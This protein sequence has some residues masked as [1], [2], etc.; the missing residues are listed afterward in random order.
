MPAA[1]LL[2]ACAA[3]EIS[4]SG[5]RVDDADIE[6]LRDLIPPI[7][8][9]V[10]MDP[11]GIDILSDDDLVLGCVAEDGEAIAYP[12]RILDF[13]EIVN[14][15][16]AVVNDELADTP[17]VVFSRAEGPAGV[18]HDRRVDGRELSFDL[19]AERITD[20]QTGS[21][22]GHDVRAVEGPLAG[23]QLEP[24]PSR[25][26]FWFA[27]VASFPDADVAEADENSR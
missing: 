26:S 3:G 2:S 22:W 14:A 20:E 23:E 11:D 16:P 5:P 10:Y 12:I 1:V 6:R 7:E 18:V 13:H 27:F 21:L 15:E 9:P 19:A 8:R 25:A 17:P 24:I 4:A